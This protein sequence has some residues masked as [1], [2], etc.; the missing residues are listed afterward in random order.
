MKCY[1]FDEIK[2]S[3]DCLSVARE[4]GL[5]VD[6]TGRC[7][8]SWRGGDNKTAVT[9]NRDGWHDFV[10][11]ESGSVI[12]LVAL[13]R[14]AGDIQKA[15][16]WLGD[17]LNLSPAI[18]VKKAPSTYK[19]RYDV[20][21]EEGYQEV[22]RYDYTDAFG[23][24]KHQTIRLEHP[25]KNKEFVQC[26]ADGK[27]GLKGVETF[28]Y[29]LPKIATSEWVVVVEGEKDADTLAK[30]NI[31]GTTNASGA[32]RWE[33][34]YTD[35][36]RGKDVVIIPDNDTA[37]EK[38][39]Y[40]VASELLGSARN[41]RIVK[42]SALPKG[43]VTDWFEKEHGTR[44]RLIQLIK[45]AE[46]VTHESLVDGKNFA[47]VQ[48]AKEAN[49]YKFR[50][51]TLLERQ[52]GNK[53]VKDKEPRHINDMIKDVHRRFLSFPRLIGNTMFDHDRDTG[54]IRPINKQSTLIS[55]IA[56]KSNQKIEWARGDGFITKEEFYEGLFA[57]AVRYES[58]SSVPAWPVR[59]DVYYTHGDLPSSNDGH[60]RFWGLVDMFSPADEAN[61]RLIAA[62]F[63]A[64][65]YY[66]P[67][68]ARPAWV[69]DSTAGAGTG[70]SSLVEAVAR[71]YDSPPMRTNKQELK[72]N[73]TDLLKRMLSTQGRNAKVL[74]IDN[75]IGTFQCPE[76]ADMISAH[77]LSGRP[78]YGR[79]EETRPNDVTYAITANSAKLDNDLADRSF[80]I[81]IGKPKRDKNWATDVE[82]YISKHRMEIFSDIIDMLENHCAFTGVEPATRVPMFEVQVLQAA[83]GT[84]EI[85]KDVLDALNRAKAES[86]IEEEQAAEIY[87]LVTQKLSEMEI[88][89]V[90]HDVFIRSAVLDK[91]LEEVTGRNKNNTQ[92]IKNLAKMNML[93]NVDLDIS[94]YPHNGP[95]RRRGIAWKCQNSTGEFKATF[96][97]YST[98][99]R[100]HKE[101]QSSFIPPVVSKK[102]SQI[103]VGE[104]E[105]DDLDWIDA[106]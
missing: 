81:M 24:I 88:S 15:Q 90:N 41:V 79:G 33:K 6:R 13:V 80:C 35:A 40:M 5:D 54:E 17:R 100:I 28:L 3:A 87:D 39:S 1:S 56:R 83:C 4:I 86:N 9:I 102:E 70:K 42:V 97:V 48:D 32:G 84:P 96:L 105:Y 21:I 23:N 75:I 19:F 26:T 43:D 89:P 11:E 99:N 94:I 98:G 85:Y 68:V 27:W 53:T 16:E 20:L 103:P 64:P 29:N 58:I 66:R 31:P 18:A 77:S 60:S 61:R 71:L 67:G 12:D 30:H 37:G 95:N 36:L 101:I 72:Y 34:S 91:W 59:S 78:S 25:E 65:V 8:A 62:F 44:E 74:L 49:R 69:I 47:A 93:K 104:I 7:A 55:W 73:V 38:R 46:P 63:M 92:V 106:P 51:F 52:Q 22:C 10:K 57:E 2:E 76:L 50:N 14:F 82:K 45:E